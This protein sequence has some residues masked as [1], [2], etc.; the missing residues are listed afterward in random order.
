M[1]PLPAPRAGS[2]M[3]YDKVNDALIYTGGATRPV[4]G[5][6]GTIEYT[7]SWM[8]YF[9]DSLSR[10]VPITDFPF[11]S[12]RLTSTNAV[13]STGKEHYYFMGGRLGQDER[14][15]NIDDLVE[16]IPESLTWMKRTD[17]H[18]TRS[19]ASESTRSY[20]CGF[21]TIGGSSNT[22]GLDGNGGPIA[23]AS[24][25][26][27]ASN[28]WTS[29][30]GLPSDIKSPVCDTVTIANEDW[31]VSQICIFIFNLFLYLHIR[32][33]ECCSSNF[34]ICIFSLFF[35]V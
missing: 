14:Q 11:F 17:M 8:Y 20:G 22:G 32:A 35:P 30:G 23:D 26:D 31:L 34:V 29:F 33:H 18:I 6:A 2:G 7:T 28:R 4:D 12:N 21:Y 24:Y 3:V 27:I 5:A 13:D 16:W 9:G 15:G 19:Y 10:W 25:Y 1:T